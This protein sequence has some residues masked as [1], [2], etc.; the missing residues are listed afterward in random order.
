MPLSEQTIT[1]LSD[2]AN[3]GE[4]V[5]HEKLFPV[6]QKVFTEKGY[7]I[8]D[9]KSRNEFLENY[10][11]SELPK[12]VGEETKKIHS[13][14]DNDLKELLGEGNELLKPK[15]GESKSY[16]INKRVL[17][18]LLKEKKELEE[19]LAKGDHKE[20][21]EKKI[22]EV[23]EQARLALESKQKDLET[24]NGKLSSFEKETKFIDAFS[25]IRSKID[26]SHLKDE[27]FIEAERAIKE[28]V[29]KNS[30]VENGTYV[31]TNPDGSV[32]KDEFFKPVTVQA[33]LEK[34]FSG[35]FKKAAEG[36]GGTGEGGN[37]GPV[38]DPSKLTPENWTPGN[39]TSKAE[40][41][42]AMAKAG[43]SMGTTQEQYVKIYAHYAKALKLT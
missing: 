26:E 43:L 2:A 32:M 11:T 14:Y 20:F 4:L 42:Q 22:Q 36:G 17:S 15:E 19:K 7:N 3:A 21:Y 38:S 37:T 35:K 16:H 34:K 33:Y 31:M 1:E 23:Q 9:E 27:M 25:P 30:K 6:I 13:A 18:T 40:L 10:K 24:L 12:L 8:M 5:G 28:Q 39:V 41:Q 29:L